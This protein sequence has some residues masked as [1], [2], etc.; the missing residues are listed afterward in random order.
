MAGRVRQRPPQVA[1]Q[2]DGRPLI[3]RNA[4]PRP[5]KVGPRHP[6][7]SPT[8]FV[9]WY[10]AIRLVCY[11]PSC[12]KPRAYTTRAT[13]RVALIAAIAPSTSDCSS[14]NRSVR[15]RHPEHRHR[16]RSRRQLAHVVQLHVRSER[17]FRGEVAEGVL[18]RSVPLTNVP[19]SRMW[20]I[21]AVV[22]SAMCSVTKSVIS[23]IVLPS[24]KSKVHVSV[25]CQMSGSW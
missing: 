20:T 8:G 16:A 15:W 17:S 18:E 14:P 19:T 11:A 7:E 2:S 1:L 22:R 21:P 23:S 6:F 5:E 25:P 3:A 4:S 12:L 24:P 13:A 10:R 9:K